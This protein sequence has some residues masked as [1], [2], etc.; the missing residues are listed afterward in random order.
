MQ[1]TQKATTDCGCCAG[2]GTQSDP[3]P[4]PS[5]LPKQP[6]PRPS[7]RAPTL[8]P[9]LALT[10]IFLPLNPQISSLRVFHQLPAVRKLYSMINIPLMYYLPKEKPPPEE[11]R[12][13][14]AEMRS[15]V[16]E[17]NGLIFPDAAM[18]LV[19]M[20]ERGPCAS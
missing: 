1:R 14:Y 2:T 5:R 6:N 9:V 10:I 16:E 7:P 17:R 4:N 8:A 20:H 12:P 15:I 13:S 3:F 19:L 18:Q 11:A